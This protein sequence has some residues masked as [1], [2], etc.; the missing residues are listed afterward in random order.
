MELE[1]VR[2]RLDAALSRRP[3]V[4]LDRSDLISAAVLVP[5]TDR[6]GPHVLFT[7]KTASVPHHKGQFS[8]PGGVVETRDG[9]RVET[10][11]REA[12]EEIRLP[13][14]AVE[15]L[16]LL[17]DTETRATNFVITPVVGI[18]RDPVEFRPDGREIERV[19]EVP[20]AT[21]RDPTIFHTEIWERNGEPHSVLF[22]RV[23]PEDVVWGATARIL[24][25]FLALLDESAPPV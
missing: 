25:Q 24:S 19:I 20:L 8:F 22:Y 5:I 15:V 23:S 17:D 11:L 9:S 6:G 1:A 14:E 10:A 12:W 13:A 21:L 2:R 16:G 4:A 7:K 3:R 18:V